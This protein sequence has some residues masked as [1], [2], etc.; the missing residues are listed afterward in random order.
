[1]AHECRLEEVGIVA[2]PKHSV[3]GRIPAIVVLV[4][5]VRYIATYVLVALTILVIKVDKLFVDH[6]LQLVGLAT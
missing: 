3:V 1:L 5:V 6:L 2:R 4:T